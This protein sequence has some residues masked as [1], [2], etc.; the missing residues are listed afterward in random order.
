[1][2]KMIEEHAKNT[3]K[4][5]FIGLVFKAS[6]GALQHMTQPTFERKK[7]VKRMFT[8]LLHSFLLY[9]LLCF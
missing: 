6:F 5:I 1:M 2:R 4:T 3:K 7:L 9:L 8:S